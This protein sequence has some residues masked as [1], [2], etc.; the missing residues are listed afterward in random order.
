MPQ[1]LTLIC[2]VTG[3]YV[4]LGGYKAAARIDFFQGVV[5]FF[6]TLLMVYFVLRHFGGFS[7]AVSDANDMFAKHCADYG[8]E[9]RPIL[10]VSSRSPIS[11]FGRLFL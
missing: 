6:G 1:V 11:F 5:M 7:E 8:K 3:I 2:V 9:G 4:F 10:T